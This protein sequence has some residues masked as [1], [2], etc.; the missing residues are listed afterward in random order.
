MILGATFKENC[1]DLRN[2]GVI[3]I[4]QLLNKMQIE[5]TVV[6][7]YVNTDPK[8]EIKYNFI[9]EKMYKKNFYDVV[10]IL[11]AHDIFKKMGIQ[12]IKMLAN[13]KNCIIMDIKS[14]FPKD[15]VDFQL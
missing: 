12:K 2:S 15:K 8:F 10:I 3:K 14:I 9:F 6:D 4:I 13:N 11:V 7:P 1:S 5:P